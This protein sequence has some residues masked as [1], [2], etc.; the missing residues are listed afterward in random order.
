MT[1]TRAKKISV[2]LST[3]VRRVVA[4]MVLVR[5]LTTHEKRVVAARDGWRCG[6][7]GELLDATYEVDHRIPLHRGGDDHVD[8][9]QA[10]HVACHKE[11]TLAEEIERLNA[12]ARASESDRRPPLSCTRCKRIVSPYFVHRCDPLR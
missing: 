1:V 12:V 8:N 6:R 4:F 2:C 7:C 5:R 9:C 3:D 11:K 10:L